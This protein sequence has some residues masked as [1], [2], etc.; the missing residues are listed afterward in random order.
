M[1]PQPNRP[2][3]HLLRLRTIGAGLALLLLSGCANKDVQTFFE[4]LKQG[5]ADLDQKLHG[6]DTEQAAQVQSADS[7]VPP[8]AAAGPPAR[9]AAPAEKK[10][11]ANGVPVA[12]ST[13][14]PASAQM[15]SVPRAAAPALHAASELV[16]LESTMVE[17]R[18]GSP[19]LRRR[20]A[21]AELWQYRSPVCVMDVFLYS[22][23]R[24]SKVMHVELHPRSAE[25]I[26]APACLASFDEPHK[27]SPTAG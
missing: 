5:L 27:P 25:Q 12:E 17:Q 23:G 24:S 11:G 8:Q 6:P 18:L 13:T 4:P 14:Q 7:E 19:A 26:P 3:A 9:A 16:G 15:A 10:P 2:V 22:D 1:M 20:D 21:P